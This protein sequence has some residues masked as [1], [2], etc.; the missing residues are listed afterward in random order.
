MFA[1]V[2][3]Y[4]VI[5]F[6]QHTKISKQFHLAIGTADGTRDPTTAVL[7]KEFVLWENRKLAIRVLTWICSLYNIVTNPMALALK[8]DHL[9]KKISDTVVQE[10]VWLVLGKLLSFQQNHFNSTP[11]AAEERQMCG[12]GS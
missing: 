10:H 7:K 2:L 8:K 1:F 4:A 11:P 9:E 5:L 6:L 12:V 3:E